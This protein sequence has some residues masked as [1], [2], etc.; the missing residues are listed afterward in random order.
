MHARR[1]VSCA[2]CHSVHESEVDRDVEDQERR[3]NLLLLPQDAARPDEPDVAP[4]GARGE[5]GCASCHNPHEGNT[6]KMLKAET[7]TEL[8]YSCHTEKRGPFLFEHAPVREDCATCHNPHGS[9]HM[10]MLN[11]K[12]PNLCWTAT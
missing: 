4:P 11:Q 7:A 10:R 1:N 3:G 12:M 5:D 2:S 8:C 6:P 9:N